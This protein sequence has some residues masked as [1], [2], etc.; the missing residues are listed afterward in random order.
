M[1]WVSRHAPALPHSHTYPQAHTPLPTSNMLRLRFPPQTEGLK[2]YKVQI[3]SLS[4]LA[5]VHLSV[6]HSSLQAIW[7]YLFINP[8]RYLFIAAILFHKVFAEAQTHWH[9]NTHL[10]RSGV[11]L[12]LGHGFF[13]NYWMQGGSDA[14]Q[15][16]DVR[17]NWEITTKR[18]SPWISPLLKCLLI[19]L[20]REKI[21]ARQCKGPVYGLLSNVWLHLLCAIEI[22]EK[23]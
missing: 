20:S 21:T 6:H 18:E 2:G 12:N 4:L 1:L 22:T 19:L 14:M 11:R 15:A 5:K 10:F 16:D 9:T 17:G 13:W 3:S 23:L 8:T 7:L